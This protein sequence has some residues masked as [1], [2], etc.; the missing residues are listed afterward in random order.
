M[1]IVPSWLSRRGVEDQVA[2]P[3]KTIYYMFTAALLSCFPRGRCKSSAG[4]LWNI[5]DLFRLQLIVLRL[6]LPVG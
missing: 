5:I 2:I 3:L 4:V 6:A 1:Q